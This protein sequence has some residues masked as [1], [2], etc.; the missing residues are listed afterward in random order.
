MQFAVQLLEK[1]VLNYAD[2]LTI[3]GPMPF[4]KKRHH[5]T[6]LEELW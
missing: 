1:E 6:N 2:I 5:L 3:L 4:D